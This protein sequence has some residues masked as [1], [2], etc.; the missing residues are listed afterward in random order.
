MRLSDLLRPTDVVIGLQAAD[1]GAAAD[2][3]L[4][5]VLAARGFDADEIDRLVREV[6]VRE[7]EAANMCGPIAI[8]HAR[9]ARIASFIAAV[10]INPAGVTTAAPVP[11]VMIAVLSPEAQRSEHLALLASLAR[12]SR[13]R[14]VVDELEAATSGEEVVAIVG[15]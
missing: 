11:R 9:D 14:A 5:Q 4:H 2:I 1:I 8:P 7:K 3:L 6:L 10:G 15:R 13:D 12:L